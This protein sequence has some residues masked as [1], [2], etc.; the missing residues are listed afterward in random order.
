LTLLVLMSPMVAT[1]GPDFN[2]H[3]ESPPSISPLVLHEIGKN[4]EM[5]RYM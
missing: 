2:R 3:Q 1:T 5:S 4:F